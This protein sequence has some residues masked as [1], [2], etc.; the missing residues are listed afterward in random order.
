MRQF[1]EFFCKFEIKKKLMFM[2]V[3]ITI[4]IISD[5]TINIRS[6]VLK[7]VFIEVC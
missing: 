3:L 1:F 5:L 4:I 2:S 6:A 7:R